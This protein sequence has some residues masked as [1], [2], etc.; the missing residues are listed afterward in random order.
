MGFI[1][2]E[3]QQLKTDKRENAAAKVFTKFFVKTSLCWNANTDPTS[4][5]DLQPGNAQLLT[6]NT[7]ATASVY[8]I[9]KKVFWC[10]FPS[11]EKLD[12]CKNPFV[13]LCL[14]AEPD[15]APAWEPN[16]RAAN[17]PGQVKQVHYK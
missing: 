10:L 1:D 6:G 11:P 13:P 9:P 14:A 2:V 5:R 17:P 4:C 3:K 7:D 8:I 15:K 16:E 12:I